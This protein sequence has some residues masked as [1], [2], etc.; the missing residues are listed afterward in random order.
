MKVQNKAN[1][2]IKPENLSFQ[3][4][5]ARVTSP[6]P[7]VVKSI[8]TLLEG[9]FYVPVMRSIDNSTPPVIG[10]PFMETQL[11]NVNTF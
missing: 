11:P 10:E 6:D 3:I 5:C 2:S 8:R 4:V 1:S 7:M 9:R